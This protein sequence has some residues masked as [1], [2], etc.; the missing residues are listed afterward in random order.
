MK[1]VL[2]LEDIFIYLMSIH[3]FH[4]EI[5]RQTRETGFPVRVE[6]NFLKMLSPK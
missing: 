2:L 3:V 6:V 4:I 1:L 5:R